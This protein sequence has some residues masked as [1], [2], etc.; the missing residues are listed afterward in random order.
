MERRF[1]FH[2]EIINL[3]ITPKYYFRSNNSNKVAFSDEL[4][5]VLNIMINITHVIKTI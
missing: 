3:L 1:V 5:R 4:H 2:I